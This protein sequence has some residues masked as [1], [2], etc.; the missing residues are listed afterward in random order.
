MTSEYDDIINLLHHVSSKH[1]HMAL[2]DRAAQFAPFAALTG[3]DAAVKET[4]RLTTKR[5]E[6]D[7]YEKDALREKLN[8]IIERIDEY[9]EITITY[10]Q[11]D[12]KKDGGA[13]LELTGCVKK[14]DEYERVICM[15]DGIKILIDEILLIESEIL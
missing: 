7:E 2:M 5:V 1:A 8:L 9:P 4:A 3:H 14:V 13:Y 11:P 15:R 6:L 12:D 10:F